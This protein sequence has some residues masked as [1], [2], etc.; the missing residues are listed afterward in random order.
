MKDSMEEPPSSAALQKARLI[1]DL[2]ETC[3]RCGKSLCL[4][5]Q[6]INLSLG[7]T[8]EMKCLI[9]LAKETEQ[10]PNKVLENTKAYILRRDCFSKE[11][12]RYKNVDFCPDKI[13]CFPGECFR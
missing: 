3:C 2:P 12:L 8:E 6:V 5:Q 1:E 7:D 9:C 10:T 11:W 4:R 13:G